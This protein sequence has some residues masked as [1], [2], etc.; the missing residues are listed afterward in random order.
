MSEAFSARTTY[1]NGSQIAPSDVAQLL[2]EA[3]DKA[4]ALAFDVSK[5]AKALAERAAAISGLGNLPPGVV[6]SLNEI[7]KLLT[8]HNLKIEQQLEKN[9]GPAV[10][11]LAAAA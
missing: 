7:N 11:P 6:T 3:K 5:D 1:F 2:S 9:K 10:A 8:E 4:R